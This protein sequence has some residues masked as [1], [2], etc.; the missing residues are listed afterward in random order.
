MDRKTKLAT[1]TALVATLVTGGVAAATLG[2]LAAA[3]DAGAGQVELVQNETTAPSSAVPGSG[4][5]AVIPGTAA[6][7]AGAFRTGAIEAGAA[8]PEAAAP[9][10]VAAAVAEVVVHGASPPTATP[11]HTSP[12]SG[13]NQPTKPTSPPTTMTTV[14][15]P[16]TTQPAPI[17]CH[18]SDD[19]M[20]EAQKQAREAACHG[21]DDD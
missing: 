3:D 12:A 4:T 2:V 10:S 16:S 13:G 18:G 6:V 5:G 19:G 11:T 17:E 14:R 7:G 21:G 15:T 20:T 9:D 1:V 8:G